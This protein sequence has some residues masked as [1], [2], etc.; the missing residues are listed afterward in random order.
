MELISRVWESMLEVDP[1]SSDAVG[2]RGRSELLV[3]TGEVRRVEIDVLEGSELDTGFRA[4]EVTLTLVTPV[5]DPTARG[6]DSENGD[7]V[8]LPFKFC[9]SDEEIELD[10]LVSSVKTLVVFAVLAETSGLVTVVVITEEPFFVSYSNALLET[11]VS[12]VG[13]GVTWLRDLTKLLTV[14]ELVL[15]FAVPWL[16]PDS[17]AIRVGVDTETRE[18]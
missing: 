1:R 4:V 7:R 17:V 2:V 3:V 13:V 6:P 10:D 14:V 12:T 11:A 16:M 9:S 18:F 8:V 5:S 15:E